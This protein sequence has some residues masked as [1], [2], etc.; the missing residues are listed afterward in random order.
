VVTLTASWQKVFSASPTL[1]FFAQRDR[2]ATAIGQG[3]V[4]APA[5]NMNDMHS[6]VTNSTVDGILAAFFALLIVIVIVDA[7]GVWV[8]AI[9]SRE[10]L[11]TTEEP[12]A[13]SLI[14]AP[15]G[16]LG[17]PGEDRRELVGAGTGRRGH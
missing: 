4:L 1:G 14:S 15:S 10:P 5:K 7:I 2:Y 13:E 12:H 11:P 16:L 3:K 8:R 6:I 17:G 9:R